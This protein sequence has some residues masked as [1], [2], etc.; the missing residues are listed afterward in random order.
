MVRRAQP[1]AVQGVLK[2]LKEIE[3]D[4]ERFE[5][6]FRRRLDIGVFALYGADVCANFVDGI[7]L[8]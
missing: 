2:G 3:F 5:M 8:T 4:S 6:L 1:G 7:S